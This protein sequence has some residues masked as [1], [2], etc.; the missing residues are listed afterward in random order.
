M[1]TGSFTSADEAIRTAI[2]RF[3]APVLSGDNADDRPLAPVPQVVHDFGRF[4]SE[5]SAMPRSRP[6]GKQLPNCLVIGEQ[7]LVNRCFATTKSNGFD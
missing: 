7:N 3:G 6:R 1:A 2:S 5:V 4:I